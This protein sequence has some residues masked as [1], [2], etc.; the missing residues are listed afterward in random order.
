MFSI[1]VLNSRM[2]RSPERRRYH[3]RSSHSI[4]EKKTKNL[5]FFP[6]LKIQL[7]RSKS[8]QR[9]S[10]DRSHSGEES[11]TLAIFNLYYRTDEDELRR[12]FERYG[13]IEVNCLLNL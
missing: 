8:R 4:F 9:S 3:S 13:K 6:V 1:W 5:F 2:T 10:S 12:I 7:K 11:N